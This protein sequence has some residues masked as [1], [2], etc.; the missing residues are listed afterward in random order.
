MIAP[1]SGNMRQ[2]PWRCSLLIYLG[3]T[4]LIWLVFGQT[5]RHQFVA[6]DDQN[7]VYENPVVTAG[8]TASGI[9]AAFA[10]PQA[11]NWHPLT[12][13]SH[14]LDCQLFGLDPAGHHFTSV[15]LHTA[16]TLLLFSVLRRMTG[17]TWRSAFVAGVF[18]IHPLRVESV[19]WVAERKDVLSAFFFMLTLGLYARYVARPRV[20]SYAAVIVSFALALMAKPM[21]VTLPFLLLLLDYWPL[22]RLGE[23]NSGNAG[24]RSNSRVVVEKVPLVLLSLGTG[25][26]T[27][28]A[29]KSTVSYGEQTPLLWRLGTA[30]T[31][32]VTYIRQMFWPAKLTV[33]Y[34]HPPGGPAPG[35]V[36]FS[37][38]LIALLTA[39]AF[40]VRKKH[41]YLIVGWLWYLICLSPTLG[42]IPVG[43]QAHADRYT[44]LPQIGLSWAIAWFAVDLGA[45]RVWAFCGTAALTG[46]T[47]LAWLQTSSWLNT[48]TLWR[49]AVTVMPDNGVAHYNL[50]V[51][52]R[53]RG[54]LD[55]AIS[56]Y[57]RALAS[58]GDTEGSSH[59]SPAI[60]H[61]ALGVALAQKGLEQEAIAHYRQ[62]IA[63][64]A[65]LADAHTNL[66][67]ALLATG[68][69][70]EAIDH[71]RKAASLPPE[72]ANSHFRL[73][74]ALERSGQRAEAISEYRRALA[75]TTDP[76]LVRRLKAAIDRQWSV[77]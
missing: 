63:L 31:A 29:Q 35:P 39:I 66:A 40:R 2:L 26:A 17:S 77:R 72:D 46:L 8:F 28:I 22:Q 74:V 18:A 41:P 36:L 75:L 56:H 58:G 10:E 38:V 12:T 61:N 25:V 68:A 69:A 34:P 5:L 20:L 6:Y 19:A 57:E 60:V 7:Y 52:E 33:F 48:E 4:S 14:M 42:L 76:E 49:H 59:L 45:R 65:D 54:H 11:R 32:C 73:A 64:R 67:T 44:Y 3:L 37:L 9:R 47:W 43:L 1:A 70:T 27:L 16:A 21:V 30:A 62:A 71:F 23:L 55:E 53:D 51:L 15:L 50:G 24:T 13:L